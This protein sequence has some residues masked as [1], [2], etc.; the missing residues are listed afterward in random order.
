MLFA[1]PD[2]SDWPAETEVLTLTGGRLR[3]V[4][5]RERRVG[6]NESVFREVNE[7]IAELAGEF[8]AS[9][10]E[11]VC[12][13]SDRSCTERVTV[14]LAAYE[15][16]RAYPERFLLLPGHQRLGVERLVE[17]Q[18]RYLVVEKL[19]EAG[20]IAEATDPRSD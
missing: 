2:Q 14:S 15:A 5:E 9:S 17:E 13:C 1:V 3:A 7:R 6:V 10:V 12:E 20:E 11:F 4:S 16:V 18:P 8:D 19:G